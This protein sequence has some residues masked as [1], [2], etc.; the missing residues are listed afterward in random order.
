MKKILI[1]I[2]L[3]PLFFVACSSSDDIPS[4]ADFDY[5]L[6]L[7]YGE[8]RATS[9]ESVGVL[10]LTTPINEL[11]AAPT[12]LKFNK[13]GTLE[14]EGLFGEGVGKYSTKEKSIHTSIGGVKKSFEVVSL[15]SSSA[16]V[17]L[18]AKG[19]GTPLIPDNAGEVTFTLTKN[20]P[21][22]IDFD[23]DINLLY[24][25]WRAVRLEGEGIDNNSVDLMHPL[26]TPTYLTFEEKGILVSEG[27]LGQ[28]TGRYSSKDKTI[29]T[30]IDKN[31][32]EL[33][34]TSI[35]KDGTARMKF[36]PTGIDFGGL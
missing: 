4:S 36:N 17:R 9:V 2:A 6:D 23:Y 16:K 1:A 15:Q 30:L 25:K 27:Y 19:L 3:M 5:N 11:S 29:Y 34:V 14:G 32:L 31:R 33:E 21:R 18:N 12:Y 22:E 26:V 24:G 20:S 35:T 28:G 10:D 13:D 8:W 7:L